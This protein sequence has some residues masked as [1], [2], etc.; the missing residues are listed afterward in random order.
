MYLGV[1]T[2]WDVAVSMILTFLLSAVVWYWAGPRLTKPEHTGK[3]ALGLFTVCVLLGIYTTILYI[4]RTADPEMAEDAL[5]ACGAGLG[6]AIGYK[7]G[8]EKALR[9]T[10]GI[11]SVILFMGIFEFTLKRTLWGSVLSYFL[12]I[13][14]IVAGYPAVFCYRE[15][16]KKS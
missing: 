1:H 6:F 16:R 15:K 8:K 14:W 13:L 5:K 7:T 2:P 12:L 3:I 4:T 11:L 9:F 10:V